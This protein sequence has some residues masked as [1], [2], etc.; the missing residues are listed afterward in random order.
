MTRAGGDVALL[1]ALADGGLAVGEAAHIIR[2]ARATLESSTET[3]TLAAARILDQ[4]AAEL[5]AAAAD[6]RY[7]GEQ[8]RSAA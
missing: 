6:Y 1:L 8:L 3:V 2:R 4:Q 5:E 7:A